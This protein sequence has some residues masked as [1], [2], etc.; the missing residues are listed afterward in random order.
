MIICFLEALIRSYVD[1]ENRRLFYIRRI[2]L[3]SITKDLRC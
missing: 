1:I 3:T 2:Q